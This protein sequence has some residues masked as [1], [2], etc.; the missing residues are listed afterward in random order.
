MTHPAPARRRA[1]LAVGVA[2]LALALAGC[3]SA[4][5]SGEP[6]SSTAAAPSGSAASAAAGSATESP[7]TRVRRGVRVREALASESAEGTPRAEP[8]QAFETVGPG[9]RT[10]PPPRPGRTRRRSATT[11]S[12]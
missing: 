10:A 3:G 12:P 2:A 6:A 5:Q 11:P 7:P 9:I 1:P 8:R 4:G